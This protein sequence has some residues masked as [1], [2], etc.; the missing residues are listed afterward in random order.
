[1][2]AVMRTRGCPASQRSSSCP[3]NP[4]APAIATLTRDSPSGWPRKGAGAVAPCA[5][6]EE[7]SIEKYKYT[8][9]GSD[10]VYD[11]SQT[12]MVMKARRQA[13]IVELVDERAGSQPGAVAH[14][15]EGSRV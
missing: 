13:V 14:P 2:A 1:M 7:V 15:A 8:A 10:S 5:A 4:L 9:T 6:S 11:N 12:R 3:A